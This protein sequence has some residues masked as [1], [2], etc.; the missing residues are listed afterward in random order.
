MFEATQ[1]TRAWLTIRIILERE[2]GKSSA[3]LV[4]Q[5]KTNHTEPIEFADK[6]FSGEDESF[7]VVIILSE[8]KDSTVIMHLIN[9]TALKAR[10]SGGKREASPQRNASPLAKTNL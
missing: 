4:I 9:G 7:L 1:L 5:I 8:L 6:L 3:P 2:K 10:Q